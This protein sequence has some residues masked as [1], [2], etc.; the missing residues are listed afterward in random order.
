VL[1]KPKR[2]WILQAEG[3]KTQRGA[4]AASA[5]GDSG[6][7]TGQGTPRERR[8]QVITTGRMDASLHKLKGA[9]EMHSGKARVPRTSGA[10]AQDKC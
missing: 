8:C 10:S 6:G 5:L 4:G 7:S 1:G 3:L 9:S 2:G